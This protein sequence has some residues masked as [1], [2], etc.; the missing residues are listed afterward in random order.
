M[1]LSTEGVFASMSIGAG[2]AL[3]VS[4][5]AFPLEQ[6]KT[7]QQAN[8]STSTF[9]AAQEIFSSSGVCGFYRGFVWQATSLAVK[10]LWRWPLMTSTPI[11]LEQN[12]LNHLHAQQLATGVLLST[13]D[14]ALL[15][16]LAKLRVLSGTHHPLFSPSALIREGWQGTASN[17]L[18]AFS[19]WSSFLV[20]QAALRQWHKGEENTLSH[21]QFVQISLETSCLVTCIATPFDT[22]ATHR[23][24]YNTRVRDFFKTT[25]YQK[26]YRGSPAAF[27]ATFIHSYASIIGLEYWDNQ[28]R[29]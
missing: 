26:M 23:Y 7:W 10:Q 8:F 29:P 1:P 5:L 18:R 4:A 19:M 16:P 15:N 25:A 17:W 27:L 24:L 22:A 12:G 11:Y 28:F 14:A 6:I 20:A 13:V 9:R 2:R 21:W 3:C